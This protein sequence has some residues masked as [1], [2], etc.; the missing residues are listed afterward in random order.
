MD[1]TRESEVADLI[2]TS[3]EARGF[4]NE[5]KDYAGL[6]GQLQNGRKYE[7]RVLALGELEAD[8]LHT[9]ADIVQG[10]QKR[11]ELFLPVFDVRQFQEGVS[12]LELRRNHWATMKLSKL[13]RATLLFTGGRPLVYF[14]DVAKARLVSVPAIIPGFFTSAYKREGRNYEEF[15]LR[16]LYGQEDVGVRR[17]EIGKVNYI[18][19]SNLDISELVSEVNVKDIVFEEPSEKVVEEI[20]APSLERVQ[21]NRRRRREARKRPLAEVI[22]KGDRDRALF[23]LQEAEAGE[24]VVQDIV[25]PDKNGPGLI[26]APGVKPGSTRRSRDVKPRRDRR[27]VDPLDRYRKGDIDRARFFL[28]EKKAGNKDVNATRVSESSEIFE[29]MRLL[30]LEGTY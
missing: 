3:L 26:G 12:F 4:A 29:I 5:R 7:V 8:E 28:Q 19:L 15:S 27:R 23:L 24:R 2:H 21:G 11:G 17:G 30:E 1:I 9:Y 22:G 14:D 6:S 18:S 20:V 25:A 16:W 10:H 13:E